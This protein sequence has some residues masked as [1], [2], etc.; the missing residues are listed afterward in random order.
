MVGTTYRTI[1]RLVQDVNY[2]GCHDSHENG[3]V[4]LSSEVT[5]AGT[6]DPEKSPQNHVTV[7]AVQA[8][9]A[10]RVTAE[11]TSDGRHSAFINDF[12][13]SMHCSV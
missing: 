1:W 12:Y 4:S 6:V 3:K 9:N 8:D 5:P 7:D 13:R 10:C 2:G 11:Q